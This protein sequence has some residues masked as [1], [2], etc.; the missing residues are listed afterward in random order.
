LE[1]FN[2]AIEQKALASPDNTTHQ[3]L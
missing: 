2:S 3:R 1:Y